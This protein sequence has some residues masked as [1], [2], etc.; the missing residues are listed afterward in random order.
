MTVGIK[1]QPPKPSDIP[2]DEIP[3]IKDAKRN[4]KGATIYVPAPTDD[5]AQFGPAAI[6]ERIGRVVPVIRKGISG[7]PVRKDGVVSIKRKQAD[8][9]TRI[10]FERATEGVQHPY[11]TRTGDGCY[12]ASRSRSTQTQTPR[13]TTPATGSSSLPATNKAFAAT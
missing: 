2:L 10:A 6:Q 8:Q 1:A 5:E 4:H 3:T 7:L 9:I 11:L 12:R 13:A